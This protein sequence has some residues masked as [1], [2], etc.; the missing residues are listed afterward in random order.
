MAPR[1]NHDA[2]GRRIYIERF[3]KEPWKFPHL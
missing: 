1:D 3:M 2:T